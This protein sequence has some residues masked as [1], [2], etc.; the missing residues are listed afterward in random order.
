MVQSA[1]DRQAENAANGLA[2]LTRPLTTKA[3]MGLSRHALSQSP[4]NVLGND[5]SRDGERD[6]KNDLF[7]DGH[8]ENDSTTGRLGQ[9]RS[10]RLGDACLKAMPS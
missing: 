1:Q 8:A 10:R 3:F 2:P 7:D 5:D 6:G 9:P 4:C